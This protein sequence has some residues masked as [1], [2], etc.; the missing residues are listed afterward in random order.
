M[1]F[2]KGT[3]RWLGALIAAAVLFKT[4]GAGRAEDLTCTQ[5]RAIGL[6]GAVPSAPQ[7]GAQTLRMSP[8]LPAE[9]PPVMQP[10][11]VARRTA[12]DQLEAKLHSIQQVLPAPAEDHFGVQAPPNFSHDD[13]IV[14]IRGLLL[15]SAE[16]DRIKN[17]QP[18]S[19][20]ILSLI[21]AYKKAPVGNTA[22]VKWVAEN[23]HPTPEQQRTLAALVGALAIYENECVV[24]QPRPPELA[25]LV[26]V[27]YVGETKW[28]TGYRIGENHVLT[29]RHCFYQRA[30]NSLHDAVATN[31]IWF[32]YSG[33]PGKRYEV[34]GED[35]SPV[36]AGTPTFSLEG[37]YIAVS[38]AGQHAPP[39]SVRA[40]TGRLVPGTDLRLFALFPDLQLLSKDQEDLDLRWGNRGG[41]V[42]YEV[43]DQCVIH[44]CQSMPGSSGAPLFAIVDDDIRFVGIHVDR[45]DEGATAACRPKQ[46]PGGYFNVGI[47]VK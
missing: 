43:S 16:R 5:Q 21:E 13:A 35:S 27:F 17:A 4:S 32:S 19:D 22:I 29:A 31:R 28:C 15:S 39:P 9:G 3:G 12:Q 44:A 8:A 34:C 46:L 42:A 26:G 18:C 10:P 24:K 6:S 37:D 41:C 33:R 45:V 20:A 30:N 40:F 11:K 23:P 7:P 1:P 36:G 47:R 25:S 2:F 14:H 38:I